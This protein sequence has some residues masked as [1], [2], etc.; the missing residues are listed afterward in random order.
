MVND[1]LQKLSMNIRISDEFCLL[2]KA[3][4]VLLSGLG[5][6]DINM[7]DGIKN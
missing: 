7:M 1:Y 5:M 4:V 3:F 6:W 2:I